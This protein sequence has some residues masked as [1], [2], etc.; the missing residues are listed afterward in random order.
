MAGQE[1]RTDKPM[2]PQVIVAEVGRRLRDDAIVCCDSGTVTAWWARHV[3]VKR[4]QLHS[5]SGTLASMAC[6]LPYAVAAQVA[7]PGRQVVA[8][9]GDGGLSMLPA[10]LATAVKYKLPIKVIVLRNDSLG[11][12]NWE[13]IVMLG[14]PEFAC[15]LQ[16]IDFVKMAAACGADGFRTDDPASCAGV[17]EAFLAAPGPAVLEAVVDAN[18]PPMPPAATA[19]QAVHFAEALARGTPHR[20]AILSTVLGNAVREMV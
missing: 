1:R 10:E 19:K 20:G 9:A 3:P 5:V 18:E 12:I 4:G 15:D 2:K 11:M 8:F 16:P 17:V 13:Q 7:H 6:G 14:N